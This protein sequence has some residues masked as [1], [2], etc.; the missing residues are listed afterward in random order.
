MKAPAGCAPTLFH[1]EVSDVMLDPPIVETTP[2]N[3]QVQAIDAVEGRM[4]IFRSWLRH[5]VLPSTIDEDRVT[6]SFNVTM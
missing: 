6:I 5:R 3:S 2:L 4:V 1:S